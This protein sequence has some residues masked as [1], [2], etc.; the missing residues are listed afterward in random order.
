[1]NKL[2]I[3]GGTPIR[4]K[5]WLDNFTT[6]EEE[7]KAVLE[8]LDSGYLSL[9]EGSHFPT[10][11]FTA[12]GGPWV[13]KLEELASD[14]LKAK[15]VISMNSASS[16]LSAAVGALEIGYGDE[17]IV[18][19]S[20]MTA[21]AIAAMIYGAVPV[22]GDVDAD[23]MGIS[24]DSIRA[25]VT[26]RTKAIMVVH[27]FGIPC[28][29]DPIMEIAHEHNL[30]VIE[31]CA[32]AWGATYKG[33]PIG[34]IGDIGVF[35]LNVNKTIQCGEG[36]LCTTNNDDLAYRL[37]LIRNH[38]EAV[39]SGAQYENLV[40]MLGFNFR[41]TELQAAV[42]YE[43][44]KKLGQLNE[45]RLEMIDRLARGINHF[46]CIDAP[47][48]RKDC[49]STYYVFPFRYHADRLGGRPL[50]DFVQA[51]NAEGMDF[52]KGFGTPLYLQSIYQ[53]R[54]VLKHGYP[55]AAPENKDSN[56]SYAPGTC[57]VAER[58]VGNEILVNERVRP[59]HS[60]DDIDDMITSV[61]KVIQAWS[62]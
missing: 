27:L 16:C 53:T 46:D 42:A 47:L 25:L 45:I 57:P 14:T 26:P 15:N 6:G 22:F 56:P 60:M 21:C 28:D 12:N 49:H 55:W 50:G 40:N 2:A 5:P 17:V 19:C 20:T 36:G 37:Q 62:V 8:V 54:T 48:G 9:F 33:R 41:L 1:M 59:P 52:I 43:Q 38:G 34:T 7:K 51:L 10:P 29:M 23:T 18:P 13:H 3:D 39:A 44:L 11:P 61:E 4:S 32:Q 24:P 35:S 58:I 31:D 30:K